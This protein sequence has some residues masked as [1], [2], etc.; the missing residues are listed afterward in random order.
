[1]IPRCSL[2][3]RFLACAL[4]VLLA[5]SMGG[6]GAAPPSFLPDAANDVRFP[7]QE[8]KFVRLVILASDDSQ[9]CIDELEIYGEDGKTNLALAGTGG[10]ATASSCLAG[11]AIHR[12]EH[13]NDG[14][15]GNAHSWIA[16]GEET[17]WAQ[18]ELPAPARVAKVVF[19]RDREGRYQDRM[20]QAIAIRLSLDGQTWQTVIQAKA[21]GLAVMPA[22]LPEPP[23]WD[24]L[25]RYAFISEGNTWGRIAAIARDSL[26]PLRLDRPAEPG[27]EPYWGNLARMDGVARTLKQMEDLVV[28]L[29]AKGLDVSAERA[30]LTA[31][32][33]RGIPP[34]DDAAAEAL[35]LEARQAK[36][37]LFLRDPA[38]APL[39]RI[40]F[41]KRHPYEPS[42]NYSDYYD[43]AFRGGG[44]IAA[45]TI[46][47]RDGRLDPAAGEVE[48][49]FDAKDGIARDPALDFEARR[50]YF[51]Y[52]PAGERQQAYWHLMVM[53]ADGRN[54]RPL[55]DGPY[56][57]YY[58]C[59]L[60]D[61]GVA[62]VST[63]C[64]GR[65][66][67]WVPMACVLFRMNADGRD[68]RPLSYANVSE[69]APTVM[70]DGRILWTR[71][72]YL[73]KGANFGHTLWGVHPDGAHPEL[74]YGNDTKNC[75]M[76]GREVPG[77]GEISC[78][79][80]SH[81][82]DFNGPIAL[83]DLRK[84]RFNPDAPTV[85]TPD[86]PYTYDNGWPQSSCF[87]DPMPVS[88]DHILVSHAPPKGPFGLYVIDRY[89]NREIL[90]LDPA[91][92]SMSPTPFRAAARPHALPS[93]NKGDSAPDGMGQFVVA[94]VYTGL[95]DKVA[96]GA[97]R[98][99]RVCEE[100]RSPLETG[101]EGRLKEEYP[102]YTDFY[103]APVT[104]G[105]GDV[106][107]PFGW[108]SYVAKGVFGTAPVETDGSANFHA[109]AGKVLYFQLLDADFN[110]IQRMRSVLQ[111]QPG[112]TRSCIG[113][114]E[115]RTAAPPVR[116]FL[117]ARHEPS[118]LKP[119][120]WGAGPFAYENVVQP[121]WNA[122]CV[123]CHDAGH[124]NGI[125]LT[126]ELDEAWVPASY[127]ALIAQGWV[128]YFSLV[129]GEAHFRAEPLTFGTVKSK[130]FRLLD[131][132]HYDVKLT[133]EEM[134][135]VKC[136]IDLNCPLW[137]D[138]I[139]RTKRPTR[140]RT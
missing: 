13:L 24:G 16:A 36:R 95:G 134:Q 56:H 74:I 97:V 65:Y 93:V 49:L 64:Q 138:Y 35:Y 88:R 128:H 112:E 10:K 68:L 73:D 19:S 85:I 96:R 78:T 69:W 22:A 41:V 60:P 17:P 47:R 70:A 105:R 98:Y 48:V 33:N 4:W 31:L 53:D 55:T 43:S 40:L 115:D 39:E 79:L 118:R 114:H 61:G 2:N 15:Y 120:P 38:L 109:P 137:P 3:Q 135:A 45:L 72:E 86:V 21:A 58:P 29:A 1:M 91:I 11:Y 28:R 139:E 77:T 14:L 125:N 42:H 124:P 27:G 126:G 34:G 32:R 46:P 26:S 119:P 5:G 6:A 9:P 8:A 90:Y 103:A 37:Q 50:I 12:V 20:P 121:V 108:P 66:L 111:L 140:T 107:G 76:N 123:R 130:L 84:G 23:T 59:P 116:P 136:W 82:G 106:N 94:D 100:V 57:D 54:P 67:C 122:N 87:R 127:R 113:C 104:G 51:A 101:R 63:R 83:V 132:G 110:E 92:G 25:L 52:R 44:G 80:I 99:L 117:A 133:P 89:G 131:A 71:S 81:F 30:Q 75:C 7:A 62:F 129:Y 102:N 18:I